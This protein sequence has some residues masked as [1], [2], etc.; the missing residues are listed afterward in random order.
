ML[1]K[2]KDF[3]FN[4]FFKHNSS[5]RENHTKDAGKTIFLSEKAIFL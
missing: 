2:H 3:H 1:K 4:I 5:E